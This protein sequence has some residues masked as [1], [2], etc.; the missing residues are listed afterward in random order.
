MIAENFREST[1]D[2]FFHD[3]ILR[4]KTLASKMR[5]VSLVSTAPQRLMLGIF[6]IPAH[7]DSSS[8][9]A[10]FLS[11][12]HEN[13]CLINLMLNIGSFSLHDN[14]PERNFKNSANS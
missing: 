9:R 1:V 13:L 14:I 11:S 6:N 12:L 5:A 8:M 2:R 10:D 4:A 3:A 7:L